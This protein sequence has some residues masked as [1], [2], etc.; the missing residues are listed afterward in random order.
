MA[1]PLLPLWL[2]YI[3]AVAIFGGGTL[4]LLK[5]H[6]TQGQRLAVL[7]MKDAG[8]TR[9]Y[10]FLQGKKYVE[11]LDLETEKDA[12]ESFTY[13][14]SNGSKIKIQKGH[15][16]GGGRDY[17][18]THYEDLLKDSDIVVFVF[19]MH[20]FL[21]DMEYQ[22]ETNSIASLINDMNYKNCNIVKIASHKDEFDLSK[23]KNK[24]Q[25][26][27][28]FCNVIK[29]KKYWDSIMDYNLFFADMRNN[30]E[31]KT[32]ADKIFK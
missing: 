24:K 14:C 22:K 17:V 28:E 16:Y 7:G 12:I 23:Q 32:I 30:D 29:T 10:R 25:I 19:D 13:T 27:N 3:I 4:I 18:K 21:Y 31:L 9:F 26:Y 11:V 6:K 5:S 8:K 20:K 2:I 1:F 15:D